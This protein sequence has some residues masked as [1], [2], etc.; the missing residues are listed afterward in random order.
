MRPF[1]VLFSDI[2]QRRASNQLG[3]R[4]I[5]LSCT[6]YLQKHPVAFVVTA[7]QAIVINNGML[8]RVDRTRSN[9]HDGA[10]FEINNLYI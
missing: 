4:T 1:M 3:I 6:L 10:R 8:Q 2:I 7:T 5:A 9:G